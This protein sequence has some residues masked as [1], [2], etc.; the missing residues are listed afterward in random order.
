M[1]TIAHLY[2]CYFILV[3]SGSTDFISCYSCLPAE[4]VVNSVCRPCFLPNY[5]CENACGPLKEDNLLKWRFFTVLVITVLKHVFS[6]IYF[7]LLHFFFCYWHLILSHL[8]ES[9]NEHEEPGGYFV[10]FV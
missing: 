9:E 8:A 10:Y 4:R 2:I 3:F 5:Q 7:L 1:R 6:Y